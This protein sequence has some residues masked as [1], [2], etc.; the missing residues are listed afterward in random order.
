MTLVTLEPVRHSVPPKNRALGELPAQLPTEAPAPLAMAQE[1][2]YDGRRARAR[3]LVDGSD[4]GQRC[5]ASGKRFQE[6]G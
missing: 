2:T 3:T 4:Q 1:E 5:R 6:Q